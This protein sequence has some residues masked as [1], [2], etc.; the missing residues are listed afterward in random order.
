LH[1]LY[2]V[3]CPVRRLREPDPQEGPN[4]LLLEEEAKH[5]AAVVGGFGC[6]S[7]K[8]DLKVICGAGSHRSRM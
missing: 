1:F 7:G 4:C 5:F 8:L 2:A 3:E 6:K